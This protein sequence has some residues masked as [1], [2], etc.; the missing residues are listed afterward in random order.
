MLIF[1]CIFFLA[2][3]FFNSLTAICHKPY[4]NIGSDFYYR[5]F[6]EKG[7]P[8]GGK[9]DEHGLLAGLNAGIYYVN[10]QKVYFGGDLRF[11]AGRTTY[12]GSVINLSTGIISPHKSTTQNWFFDMEGRIGY[13]F[14]PCASTALIPFIGVG[15]HHWHRGAT[16]KNPFGYDEDY[17]WNYLSLGVRSEYLLSRCVEIGLNLKLMCMISP[18]MVSSDLNHL[19]FRLG[20]RLQYEIE[21]P[22]TFNIMDYSTFSDCI[23][24][25]PYYRSQDIGRSN[26]ML[27]DLNGFILSVVEPSSRAHLF[28]LRLELLFFF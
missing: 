17:D 19:T 3:I 1:R 11:T 8:P 9:S 28:G 16:S 18:E 14:D 4:F 2:I 21:V 15:H 26:E 27:V 10:P 13:T 22:I 5:D 6:S 20:Q 7:L 24:V 25:T 23:R 12:D